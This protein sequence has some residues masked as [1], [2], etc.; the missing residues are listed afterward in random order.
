MQQLATVYQRLQG[1][2]DVDGHIGFDQTVRRTLGRRI[3]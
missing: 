3:D 1:T 2:R